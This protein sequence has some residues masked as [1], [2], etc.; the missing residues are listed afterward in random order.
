MNKPELFIRAVLFN[1]IASVNGK[2]ILFDLLEYASWKM[3][4]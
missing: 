4:D 2:F 1:G 3:Q